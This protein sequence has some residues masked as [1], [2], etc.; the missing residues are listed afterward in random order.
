MRVQTGGKLREAF[1]E[2]L[3]V[4]ALPAD[5]MPPPLVRNFV[6][7]HL[8]KELLRPAPWSIRNWWRM[9]ESRNDV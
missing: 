9:V 8:L 3:V 2:P 1:G 6:R 5:D 7:S 4:I